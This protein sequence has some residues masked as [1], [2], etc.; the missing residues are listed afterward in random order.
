MS[1]F[2]KDLGNIHTISRKYKLDNDGKYV[3][4]N[5]V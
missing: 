2:A 5:E 3:E 1:K 4:V